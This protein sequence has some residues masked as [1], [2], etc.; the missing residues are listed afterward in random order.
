MSCEPPY[1][2]WDLNGGLF[3]KYLF[4]VCVHARACMSMGVWGSKES[5]GSCVTE[6]TDSCEPPWGCWEPNLGPFARAASLPSSLLSFLSFLNIYLVYECFPCMYGYGPHACPVPEEVRGGH[7]LPE[8]SYGQLWAAMWVQAIKPGP[9]HTEMLLTTLSQNRTNGAGERAQWLWVFADLAECW[10]QFLA[11]TSGSL[12]PPGT[13]VSG[14]QTPSFS[15]QRHLR[16]HV[17][18][19]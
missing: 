16:K 19:I 17:T 2:Y 8:L 9:L 13:L 15:L 14:N 5:T 3:K 6:V 10:A 4:N 18:H 12:Q 1:G 11:L 7:W